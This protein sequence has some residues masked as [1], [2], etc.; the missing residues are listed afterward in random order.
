M[1]KKFWKDWQRRIGE[2]NQVW[3]Y[4]GYSWVGYAQAHPLLNEFDRIIN[5]SFHNDAV[6]LVIERHTLL[7]NRHYHIENE[8][9]TL[10]RNEIK[11]ID[12]V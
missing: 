9:K 8:Y 12:F 1:T 7:L 5:A 6:D 2:T 4:S 3:V 11:R 10:H